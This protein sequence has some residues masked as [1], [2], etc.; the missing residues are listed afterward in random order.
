M[1]SSKVAVLYSLRKFNFRKNKNR[2]VLER[3]KL[4]LWGE[5]RANSD[6]TVNKR[7]NYEEAVYLAM[8]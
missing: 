1:F 2:F 7:V 3:E 6:K 5:F 8:T 4:I